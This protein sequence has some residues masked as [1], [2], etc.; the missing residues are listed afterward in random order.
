MTFSSQQAAKTL[1]ELEAV[2]H[3]S[4]QLYRYRR[5]APLLMLWGTIWT[6]GFSLSYFFP[7][8]ASFAWTALDFTGTVGCIYIA[9]QG[10]REKSSA[11]MWRWLGSIFTIV[12]FYLIVLIIFQPTSGEQSAV[13]AAL[14]V[15]LFYT[16]SGIWLG[17]RFAIAGLSVAGL[18]LIG[19]FTLTAYFC[20]WMAAVGGGALM[21]AGAWLRRV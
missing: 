8:H 21:L 16:L 17:A 14:L 12:A 3:R 20:L 4:E 9:R 18:T 15:A 13:L 11:A 2:S 19:Y 6:L 10:R 7:A 1:R 5:A